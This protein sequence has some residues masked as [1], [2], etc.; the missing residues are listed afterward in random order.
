MERRNTGISRR[1][2]LAAGATVAF[3]ALTQPTQAQTITRNVSPY[4]AGL[5]GCAERASLAEQ[6]IVRRHVRTLWG[7]R[8]KQLGALAWPSSLFDQALVKWCYWWQ[9]QLLDCA[10]D[11]AQRDRTPERL[12]RVAAL[13]EGIRARNLTGW[14]NRYYDDMAWLALALERADRLLGLRFGGAL[15][16]LRAAL[17]SGWNPSVGA[18]P[19]RTGDHYYNTPAIGPTGIAL[20]RLGDLDRARQLAEFL[21]TR[22]RDPATDLILDGVHEPG[23]EVNRTVLTYCQGV[24]IGLETELAIHTGDS[25]HRDRARALIAATETHLTSAGVIA[26]S[27]ADDSGLFMGILARYLAEAALSLDNSTAAAMVHASARAAWNNRAESNG[28]P[29]FGMNWSRPIALP[30]R[31]QAFAQLT[32]PTLSDNLSPDLSVQLSAWLLL[33]A[34]HRLTLAGR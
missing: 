16:D 31:P 28:L 17:R 15:D 7:L 5:E 29:L 24:A 4:R 11:A 3:T 20:A 27:A 34:D 2:L 14:T 19:W 12:D 30:H 23:G 21:H 8:G 9:A 13:A 18:V 32:T 33:E 25:T 10:V 6:A 26:G 1:R 22:L